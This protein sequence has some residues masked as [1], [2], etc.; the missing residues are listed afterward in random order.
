VSFVRNP[1]VKWLLDHSY[2]QGGTVAVPV[3]QSAT[4]QS[5]PR[6]QFPPGI[7]DILTHLS[8]RYGAWVNTLE[9]VDWCFLVGG[10]GNGKSEALRELTGK[11]GMTLPSPTQG[12]AVPRTIPQNWPSTAH[13]LASG[14]E[15]VLINDASIPRTGAAPAS[16]FSDLTDALNRI[17]GAGA[18][19]SVF[20]N[21]NRG[22]LVEEASTLGT[23]PLPNA[24]DE[25]ARSIV[26]WLAAPRMPVSDPGAA[27]NIRTVVV[28][29]ST[30]P[31]YGQLRVSTHGVVPRTVVVH[32]IFLDT[33]SLLEP[34]PGR[35]GPVIDFGSSPPVVAQY[36]TFGNLVSRDISR[37][38]TTAGD[39][40]TA[41][42]ALSRWTD[43]GCRDPETGTLCQAHE[44][45]PFAQNSK[46]IQTDSLRHRFLDT[47]RA[48]EVAAGRRLTYRDL[49]GH[50]SLSLIGE[51]EEVWLTGTHPCQ[52]SAD[53][54]EGIGSGQKRAAVNLI[55][56]RIYATLFPTVSPS[57][58]VQLERELGG[59]TIY[60]SIKARVTE[61]GEAPRLEA[62]ERAFSD[63]DPAADTDGWQG[64]R[65]RALDAVE[66]LDV[67]S[68]SDQ[69]T[70]WAEV[71]AGAASDLEGIVDQALREEID[72]ELK[73]GTKSANNRVRFLRNWRS[74]LLLRQA[75]LALGN[76]THGRA[77]QAWLAEQENALR[78]GSRLPLGDGIH[79]LIVPRH[80]SNRLYLAPLRP[81]TY[82]L[83]NDLPA[84]TLLFPIT[85]NDLDVVIVPH[86]DTMIAEV[87]GR[88]RQRQA[89]QTLAA[90]AI[91]LAV[92]RE[93]ILHADDDGRSF[94]EIGYTAFARI[95]RARASLISRERLKAGGI[96]FT[97]ER[98]ELFR[99]VPNPTGSVPLRVER[100]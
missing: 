71:A 5:M 87:Q 37:D 28:P 45:C 99:V 63:I 34:T 59:D 51:P 76:L 32:V 20:G 78:A 97:N 18:P 24:S 61:K 2:G 30:A 1:M 60:G 46:W 72:S 81:R 48:A 86:G 70:S 50:I 75:G 80:E 16:L 93:A 83:F 14:L 68:P 95:E 54:H 82:C 98:K 15:I 35:G 58:R 7:S 88:A 23:L 22:I 74:K 52:W 92:A 19:V 73:R 94:T 85:I 33:L 29:D 31:E 25:L 6:G 96:Y 21:V 62:F 12:Q 65:N 67:I 4:M 3:A 36:Q 40:V 89:P 9:E 47:L 42:S 27:S 8:Q 41:V 64:M 84:S 100:C 56:H 69:L 39:F 10:P 17:S 57:A 44:T 90:L 43:G 79:N 77:I 38:G 66:S 26:R 91:D 11:L 55:S 53:Q 13:A 49:L